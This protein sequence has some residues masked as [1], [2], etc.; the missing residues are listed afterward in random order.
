[1]DDDKRFD[2]TNTR[3]SGRGAV[4]LILRKHRQGT[5]QEVI[6]IEAVQYDNNNELFRYQHMNS[7]DQRS[8]HHRK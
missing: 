6:V 7:A 4:L 2:C 5:L 1:M 8:I 3:R